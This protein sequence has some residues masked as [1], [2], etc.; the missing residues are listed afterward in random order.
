MCK[1]R[2]LREHLRKWNREVFGN[3]DDQLKKAENELHEWDLKAESRSLLETELKRKRE[4]R[5]QV[6][7]LSRCKARM[8]LQKSRLKLAQNGDKNT[9]LFHLMASRRQRKNL[10]GSVKVN[11]VVFENPTMV[12]QVVV[13]HFSR[14]FIENWK[15]RP[16]L[17]GPFLS[18]S[19]ADTKDVL[20]AEFSEEFHSNGK[21][22]KGVNSSFITLIPKKKNP[23][24]LM[25]KR[26]VSFVSSNTAVAEVFEQNFKLVIGYG[27]RIQFWTD[28]WFNGRSLRNDFPRL[29]SLSM[30]KEGTLKFFYQRK[31]QDTNWK[32]EL[33]RP[34]LA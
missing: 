12:R 19:P 26:I 15:F 5:S 4:I 27:E 7:S 29:F 1:L 24:D 6:W 18:I 30:D 25:W 16:K 14:V 3:I 23:T 2:I 33:R 13:N 28:R 31:W 20:E 11:G 10:L 8:W 34:L 17:L 22:A 9:R 21:M 32:P